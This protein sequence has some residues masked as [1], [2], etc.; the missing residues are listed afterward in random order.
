M[1]DHAREGGRESDATDEGG[2]EGFSA[3]AQGSDGGD[4]SE[5]I[6]ARAYERWLARGGVGGDEREDW[7]EAEREY[8]QGAQRQQGDAA[9]QRES[10]PGQKRPR[11]T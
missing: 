11:R 2:A 1:T 8:R 4:E 7:F 3:G 6:R 10:E 5:Q 9:R